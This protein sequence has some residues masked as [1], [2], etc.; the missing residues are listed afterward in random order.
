MIIVIFVSLLTIKRMKQGTFRK[1]KFTMKMVGYGRYELQSL[2][3]GVPI[4]L[5]LS[6]SQIF[7]WIDD[8][9]DQLRYDAARKTCYRMIVQR[10][11][12]LMGDF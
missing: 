9:S 2:Y 11:E 1:V 12:D 8:D 4:T 3:K 6:D 7:D 10:Y 5:H